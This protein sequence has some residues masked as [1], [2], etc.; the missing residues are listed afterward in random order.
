MLTVQ[1]LSASVAQS[2]P[3]KNSPDYRL[4]FRS[5][6][7]QG[8][9]AKIKTDIAFRGVHELIIR[10]A[11]E[12]LREAPV[13]FELKGKRLLDKATKA[14]KR[15]FYLSYA[16]R[17]TRNQGYALR[18]KKEMMALAGFPEW[19]PAHFLDVAEITMALAIGLD[20]L[21][22]A[23][24]PDTK[25]IISQAIITK[26]LKVSLEKQYS[27]WADK[28]TNWNPICNAGMVFG[29][30][31]TRE[32]DPDLYDRIIRRA[33]SSARLAISAYEPDGVYPEGYTYWSYGT[34]FLVMLLDAME[35]SGVGT[36]G[37]ETYPGFYRTAGY[38]QHMI[39]PTGMNFNY[40]DGVSN[41]SVNPAMF[42]FARRLK[43]PAVLTAELTMMR[44]LKSMSWI[45]ELPMLLVWGHT[46][47]LTGKPQPA[48][49]EFIGKG[50]NPVA[51]FRSDWTDQAM[52][53][54]LKAG[55]P[56][57]S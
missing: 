30:I 1:L 34:T 39:G 19:N 38:I 28:D 31:V 16:W 15:I 41:S 33:E 48:N 8:I 10:T 46:L 3:K 47:D 45:P 42:W 53:I 52:Y 5:S 27:W 32:F 14:R 35:R 55:S 7:E 51:M 20:W 49:Q 12:M 25:K 18:A 6:D 13:F 17:M 56:S 2:Q 24:D 23:L 21:D 11:D 43:N 57:V 37:P 54:G 29:A 36:Y 9:S 4:L 40:S 26:G 50:K 22:S 44:T